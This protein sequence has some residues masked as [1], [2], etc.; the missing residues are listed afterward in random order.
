MKDIGKK[1]LEG[2][3]Y[4]A[5]EETPR[6]RDEDS[7]PLEYKSE[8]I[9]VDLPSFDA[10]LNKPYDL[11]KAIIERK[12]H[13]R[14]SETPLTL[15][16][17]SYLLYI[18][19]GVKKATDKATFRTVPGAGARHAFLTYI[20][21]HHVDGLDQ[22]LY[23]YHALN[24]KLVKLKTDATFHK[25]LVDGA[26]GQKMFETA[27]LSFI[28]VADVA[29]MYYAYGERGYRYLHLDAG[30]VCQNLYL[31]CEVIGC[32]TVAVAAFDD[33]KIN[34]LL[35]LDGKAYFTTYMAPVGKV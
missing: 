12:S 34:Q 20:Y 22:G 5:M 17:V 16:E 21:V 29:R 24:H 19:Q 1:F 4:Q 10:L 30:H 15:E 26:L 31:G 7:P 9:S 28:W 8:G 18:T 35:A 25:N 6:K 3:T 27:A 13:R 2:T 33:H 14:Y 32:G 11:N 23:R